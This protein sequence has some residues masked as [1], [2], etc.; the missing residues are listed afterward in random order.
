[1]RIHNAW[2][3]GF[4]ARRDARQGHAAD[5]GITQ[6]SCPSPYASTTEARNKIVLRRVIEHGSCCASCFLCLRTSGNDLY[7]FHLP[8]NRT[9][10]DHVANV[11]PSVPE[12]DGKH[13]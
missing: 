4:I 3:R 13:A 11:P 7:F 12:S 10:G 2:H 5:N 9:R 6:A 1:M 8:T